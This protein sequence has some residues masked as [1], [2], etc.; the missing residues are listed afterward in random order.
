MGV[1]SSLLHAIL[2]FVHCARVVLWNRPK[3]RQWHEEGAYDVLELVLRRKAHPLAWL[4]GN[5][6]KATRLENAARGAR[7]ALGTRSRPTGR[8]GPDRRS[9]FGELHHDD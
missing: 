4:D 6:K 7:F 9:M 3:I 5:N 2:Y 1:H 8:T